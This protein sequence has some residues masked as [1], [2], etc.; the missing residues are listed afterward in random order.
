MGLLDDK[1]PGLANGVAQDQGFPTSG[2]VSANA[3]MLPAQRAQ[4]P[5]EHVRANNM[6]A[7]GG[8]G[9]LNG[10]AVQGAQYKT[11]A[12]QLSPGVASYVSTPSAQPPANIGNFQPPAAP[13]VPGGGQP[14][15]I[16]GGG[17]GFGTQ[18]GALSSPPTDNK[19]PTLTPLTNQ[20]NGAN[21]GYTGKDTTTYPNLAAAQAAAAAK[22]KQ[23]P[24]F[25]QQT[26][27]LTGGAGGTTGTT[28]G[29]TAPTTDARSNTVNNPNAYN[30]QAEMQKQATAYDTGSA[31]DVAMKQME[32]EKE[33]NNNATANQQNALL[34]R[35]A[36]AG[37]AQMAYANTVAATD[38]E[39]QRAQLAQGAHQQG[40]ADQMA[41]SKQVDDTKMQLV[42]MAHSMGLSF[43]DGDFNRM[44]SEILAQN[45]GQATPGSMLE[46]LNKNVPTSDMTKVGPAN[47][48]ELMGYVHSWNM[49]AEGKMVKKIQGMSIAERQDLISNHPDVIDSVLS[50]TWGSDN[51][52][53]ESAL[54]EAGWVKK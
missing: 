17:A 50:D 9:T 18:T 46:A 29:T 27:A 12:Q 30:Y 15:Y 20:L 48:N 10:G 2:D 47:A 39:A 33:R 36:T 13:T 38:A 40:F 23:V 37:Q 42:Q 24:N 53:I 7:P 11:S 21:A 4:Q 45:G 31:Y 43:S 32:A 26:G 54:R 44:S 5:F 19:T 22:A 34:G 6:S 35:G 1:R 49:D 16:T 25:G 8:G 3:G 51:G 14:S 28:G 52:A 41:Y